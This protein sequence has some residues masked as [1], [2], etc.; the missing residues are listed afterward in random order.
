[1]NLR[2][3]RVKAHLVEMKLGFT[4]SSGTLTS[5]RALIWEIAAG[6]S[7]GLGE[8]G[9]SGEKAV[10]GM[11]LG[12]GGGTTSGLKQALARWVEPLIGRDAF[13]L[14]ALLEPLP[15][16]L[17]WDLLVVREGLSI[18]LHDLVGKACGVPVHTLLGGR[19]RNRLP[20][21]PVIHVG[22][23][24]VM[25]R[26]ARKWAAAGYRFLKIKFRGRLEEDLEALQGI[27]KAV[28]A[29]VSLVVDANDGYKT[30]DEA[31]AAIAALKACRI[32]YFEDMLDAPNEAIAELRRRTGSRIMVDRQSYWPNI[33]EIVRAG[34]ADVI[35]HHPDN[36]GGLAT[37]LQIDAVARAAG[38]ETAIGSSGVFGI[39]DAAFMQL[40]CV[41]GLT[42]PCEDIGMEP[43]AIGPARGEYAFD[44]PPGVIRRAYPI[45]GGVIAVPDAPGLGVEL[46]P[47]ALRRLLVDQIEFS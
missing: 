28:G 30:L 11:A 19:R 41:I 9:F 5:Q 24:D 13:E 21:M 2:I 39:Q 27:R 38:L 33:H 35:N 46:D 6:G 15:P 42:R 1:M 44:G 4:Y 40:A 26:R 10:P 45:E 32:D 31:V 29:G 23:A 37:A 25:V 16:V 3:E 12:L 34:A 43:Y 17:D 20:G 47:A 18:A 14:E 8:C 22:P 36:Q 7:T